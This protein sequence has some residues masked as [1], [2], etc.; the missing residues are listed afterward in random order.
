[1]QLRT[2]LLAGLLAA[3]AVA[4]GV[5]GVDGVEVTD[6]TIDADK[7]LRGDVVDT[8]AIGTLESDFEVSRA[9]GM[10]PVA[11]LEVGAATDMQFQRRSGEHVI[12]GETRTDTVDLAFVGLSDISGSEHGFEV[13]DITDPTTPTS[14]ATVQCGGFHNDIA[15]WRDYVVIGHDGDGNSFPC[16]GAPAIGPD[17]PDGAGVYVFDV[18]DPASPSFLRFFNA[19]GEG[20]VDLLRDG[21]HNLSIH[22][23]GIVHF[24]T[25]SFDADNPGFG[26]IDLTGDPA[27]WEQVVYPMRDI[28]PVVADGCHDMGYSFSTETPMMVCPAIEDT[29]V[30]DITDPKQP[31][32]LATIPN[33]AIN[34]HHGG[35]FTPDGTTA[36]LGD[37]LAGA[38]APS[39]CFNGGPIG[40]MWTYDLTVPQAP[41]PT[42]YVSAAE[43]PS[44]TIETCTSHFYNFVPNAEDATIV[45]TG[46]YGGGMV[47]HDLTPIVEAPIA[48]G[49]LV[50]AGPETA[51]LEPT[52]AEMWNAYAYRGHVYG[53]SY[54]GNTGF[55]VASLDG[56]TGTAD[57]ELAPY[58]NDVGIVWGPWTDDWQSECR[59]P[60]DPIE[61]TGDGGD[62]E[63][64][65]EGRARAAEARA[66]RGR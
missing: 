42:G 23:D 28:S 49:G 58:C 34:I 11:A 18:S 61:P 44:G 6:T 30:W 12:A 26:Y 13:V 31:V 57:A 5:V 32:E 19:E 45:V 3:S 7:A 2:T 24:A 52:G 16:D 35:R 10:E 37:E 14:L 60:G 66:D 63:P 46:W 4:F 56:Y 40:A 9:L 48:S 62:D 15:V 29:F 38:G 21:T 59:N 33:P 43:S 1:M 64:G 54:T 53:N 50:G 55:F 41:V 65:A 47:V 22:P 36:V 27:D 25:A 8:T 39:G 17:A 20:G 51:H